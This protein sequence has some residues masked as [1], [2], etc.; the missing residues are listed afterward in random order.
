MKRKSREL[1][2]T[3]YLSDGRKVDDVRQLVFTPDKAAIRAIIR[4]LESVP[5]EGY[6][7]IEKEHKKLDKK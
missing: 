5:M 1:F 4:L 2:F 7:R 6:P 3:R